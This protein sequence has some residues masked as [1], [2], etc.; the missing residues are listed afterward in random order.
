V[1]SILGGDS[2]A[3]RFTRPGPLSDAK[4]P[5]FGTCPR[6]PAHQRRM[7]NWNGRA[8]TFA[9]RWDYA[10]MFHRLVL[11]TATPSSLHVQDEA[12]TL[13]LSPNQPNTG[14]DKCY[15]HGTVSELCDAG[16]TP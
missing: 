10:P 7:G 14:W 3:P 5:P 15:T 16:G 9:A 2:S 8:P 4:F 11:V 1:V 12:R 6:N 13:S